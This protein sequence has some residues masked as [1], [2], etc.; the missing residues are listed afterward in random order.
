M[1]LTLDDTSWRF[2]DNREWREHFTKWPPVIIS[3]AITGGIHGKAANP[4][5]P[6]TP[7]EQADSTYEAYKAGCS[8]VHIHARDPKSNYSSQSQ[9]AEDFYRV[10]KLIRERCPDIIINNTG[11]PVFY[12]DDEE[13]MVKHFAECNPEVASLDVGMLYMRVRI[14]AP[15]GAEI[16]NDNALSR[17]AGGGFE[18]TDDGFMQ[19]EG[20]IPLGYSKTEKLA[21]AMRINNVKAELEVFNS[22]SWWFVDNLISKGLVDPPYWCQL[23][24]GQDGA[25]SPP[26]V[27]TALEMIEN[28]PPK[29]LFSAIGI[30]PLQLPVNALSL[31]MGGHIRV[32]MEDNVYYRKGELSKSNAQQV[33]RAV[34]IVHELNREVA[35]P[36]QAREMIGIDQTPKEY[37]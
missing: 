9:S 24:F 19:F 20:V 23:V 12:T 2:T 11:T 33:E 34:R 3:C 1:A 22:Q 25:C 31:I 26:T 17:L 8:I 28:M 16:S 5:L 15:K 10:N 4:D 7:E 6:E 36:A 30:G 21:R 13:K 18:H 14:K 29:S 35:T 27:M 37:S 32:G